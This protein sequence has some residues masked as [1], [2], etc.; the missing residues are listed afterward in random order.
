M[1]AT[2]KI[3]GISRRIFNPVEAV[4]LYETTNKHVNSI[5]TE[6]PFRGTVSWG[7][8]RFNIDG[9]GQPNGETKPEYF[10]D[11]SVYEPRTL[12]WA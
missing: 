3:G 12:C 5:S 8:Y 9:P 4:R 10:Q 1:T 7:L 6:N 11:G 2:E